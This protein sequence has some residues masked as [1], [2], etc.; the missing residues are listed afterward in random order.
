MN[1]IKFMQC[2]KSKEG[3]SLQEF[4]QHWQKYEEEVR[5]LGEAIDAVRV[6][7]STTLAVKENIL[8]MKKRD[9]AWP[10]DGIAELWM[11]KVDNLEARLNQPAVKATL[12]ALQAHQQ[13]FV[14]IENSCFFFTM[15]NVLFDQSA[16]G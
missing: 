5:A 3:I 16:D 11:K 8:I 6:T 9:S 1:M 13:E 4:R 15:E 2:I 7:M 10:F 12:Q 14:D